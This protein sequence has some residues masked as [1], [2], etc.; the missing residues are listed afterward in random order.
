MEILDRPASPTERTRIQTI[1][2]ASDLSS[3]STDAEELA[4]ELATRLRG[5]LLL[6]SVIDPRGLWTPAGGYAQRIDQARDERQIAAG[7]IVDR[8]HREGV[9]VRTLIWD[10]DPAES[11]V[12]AAIA[13][14]VDLIVVGSHQRRGLDRLVMGSVSE[15]V[16]RS[17]PVSVVVARRSL[18]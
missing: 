13:E 10:G 11:I 7:A 15:Q 16:V 8:A 5:G 17:S 2:L 6:V 9:P 1:L 14:R 3:A 18:P 4:F 12:A